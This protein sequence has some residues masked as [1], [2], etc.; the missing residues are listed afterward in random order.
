MARRKSSNPFDTQ[1]NP[2]LDM[3][4]LIDVAFLL[5]IYF[6][7]ATQLIQSEADIDLAIPGTAS[8]Q[9][10][11]VKIDPMRVRI[12]ED[13]RILVNEEVVVDQPLENHDT[14]KLLDRLNRYSASIKLAKAE[15]FV[16]IDCHDDA[17]EQRFIDVLNACNAVGIDNISLAE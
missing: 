6:I 8:V 15:A 5:L 4:P 3:S 2:E 13:S 1:D 10:K 12:D 16:I 11:A 14:P 17:K 9:G 7:V